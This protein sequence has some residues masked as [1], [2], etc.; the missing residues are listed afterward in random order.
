MPTASAA[1]TNAVSRVSL[2]TVRK[3]MIDSAPT[4]VNAV[5]RLLRTVSITSATISAM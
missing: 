5:A 4:S 1:N 3:R 2:T